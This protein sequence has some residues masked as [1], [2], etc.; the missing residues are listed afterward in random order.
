MKEKNFG[1]TKNSAIPRTRK[2][3]T[4]HEKIQLQL[5]P[6]QLELIPQ[7]IRKRK[8]LVISAATIAIKRDTLLVI[9]PS[10]QKTSQKTSYSLGNLHAVDC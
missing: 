1:V 3:I 10:L 9:A 2:S 8:I 4:I 5:L 6:L 7:V